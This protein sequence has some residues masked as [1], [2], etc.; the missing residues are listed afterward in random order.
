MGPLLSGAALQRY[1]SSTVNIVFDGNSLVSG[2]GASTAAK[3]LP[4]QVAA[5]A[6]LNGNIAVANTGVSGRAIDGMTT[7][8]DPAYV[9]GKKNIL[10]VW[11]GTNTICNQTKTG[12]AAGI[13]MA[14]YCNYRLTAHPDWVIIQMT[15]LPRFGFLQTYSVAQ[16]NA[17]LD[18]Y[19]SY[20]AANYKSMGC[21]QLIDVRAAGIF[22]YTGTTVSTTMSPY[23]SDTTH[24]NDAGYALVAQYVANTLRRLSSR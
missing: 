16:A 11:E 5:L 12:V 1:T 7:S 10:V 15:T 19:N 2:V 18:A 4:A 20:L 14:G 6:P 22:T 9:A 3:Y 8:A 24:C 17:E 23:M 13:E 21:K